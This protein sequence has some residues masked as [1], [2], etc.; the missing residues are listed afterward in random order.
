MITDSEIQKLAALARISLSPDETPRF[1]QDLTNILNYVKMLQEVDVKGI[2]PLSHV[3]GI[4]NVFR[5]DKVKPTLSIEE[6]ID[7]APESTGRFF[8]TPLIIE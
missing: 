7:N 6:A 2:E 5:E 3:H 1:K 4:S 8:K